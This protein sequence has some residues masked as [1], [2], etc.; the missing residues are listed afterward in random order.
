M[1]IS[2]GLSN[3]IILRIIFPVISGILLFL[4]F[5]PFNL[6]YLIF[7]FTIPLL[8]SIEKDRKF[9]FLKGFLTGSIFYFFHLFWI[10]SLDVG[11]GTKILILAG[12]L[13]L[14]S[15]LSSYF[16]LI[17]YFSSKFKNNKFFFLLSFISFWI[18]LDYLR[19]FSY[20]IGFPWGNIAYSLSKHPILIQIS[21]FLGIY[22]LGLWILLI[23][24]LIFFSLKKHK[25]SI[26]LLHLI[27][28]IPLVSGYFRLQNKIINNNEIRIALLQPNVQQDI[29]GEEDEEFIELRKNILLNFASKI[30]QKYSPDIIVFPETSWP[31]PIVSIYSDN[32]PKSKILLDSAES[33]NS[34]LLVGCVDYQEFGDFYRPTNSIFFIDRIGRIQGRYNKEYL[35]PFGEHLPFDDKFGIIEKIEL[36]QSSYLPGENKTLFNIN[37]F[38]IGIGI[39][40]ESVFPEHY[41]S[42]SE[43]DANILFVITDDQWFGETPGPFQHFDISFLRA[44]ENSLP[45]LRASNTGITCYINQYGEV[46]N[47]LSRNI[48]GA[49]IVDVPKI[50]SNKY[51]SYKKVFLSIIFIISFLLILF[52]I[53]KHFLLRKCRKKD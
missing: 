28:L 14:V 50:N 38:N 17:T 52:L 20:Q 4:S 19:S 44:V 46:E 40:F 53:F 7:V 5:P 47:I 1:R 39:C 23:N 41:S 11:G 43:K 30:V 3:P 42:L 35:V 51:N 24:F 21:S 34:N 29:K 13:F 12:I 31:V 27:I 10:Y 26:V 36:G 25:I 9:N 15:Y 16:G 49:L 2:K 33:W 32:D 37:N 18:T 48:K 8:Y 22:G 6:F 45:L